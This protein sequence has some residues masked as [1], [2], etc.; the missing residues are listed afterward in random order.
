MSSGA[1]G[2]RYA[3]ALFEV[4]SDKQQLDLVEQDLMLID[5]VLAQNPA[6]ISFLQHP[7]LDKQLKKKEFNQVFEGQVSETVLTFMNLLIDSDREDAIEGIT[8]SYIRQANE[9]R[10]LVDAK[11]VSMKPLTDEEK[12][13]LSE[14]F[15]QIL[16]KKIRIHNEVDSS[17][18]GGIIVQIGDRLYDGSV[19][20]KLHRFK[21]RV[22]S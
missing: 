13:N 19:R 14:R 12:S 16:N 17:I 18:I 3:K 22:V 2:K 15:S 5:Q 10:G 1:V 6:F 7:Q 4:A 8:E 21:R 9:A 20:G 11:V